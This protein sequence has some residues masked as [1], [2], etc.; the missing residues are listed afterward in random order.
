MPHLVNGT[1]TRYYGKDN[2]HRHDAYCEDCGRHRML[3]SYDARC[4]VALFFL[5]LIPLGKR[6]IVDEC[7]DCHRHR[8]VKLKEWNRIR[9]VDLHSAVEELRADPKNEK[10]AQNALGLAVAYQHAETFE[11]SRLLI[12]QSL[13]ENVE[14]MSALGSACV[15]FADLSAAEQA[16]ARALEINDSRDLKES[17]GLVLLRQGKPEIAM[18]RLAH[19]F[20]DVEPDRV[21]LLYLL[22]EGFQA[23]G[24]HESALDVLD[25]CMTNWNPL[26]NDKEFNNYRNTSIKHRQSD[27]KIASKAPKAAKI[28]GGENASQ[29]TPLSRVVP[30]I[31]PALAL[32]AAGLYLFAA[33]QAGVRRVAHV[34][35]GTPVAYTV[36]ID[37]AELNLPPLTRVPLAIGE[38]THRVEVRDAQLQQPAETVEFSTPFWTRPFQSPAFV[39]NPDRAAVIVRAETVF[40]NDPN[41]VPSPNDAQ[42]NVGQMFYSFAN[43]D[44]IFQDFPEQLEASKHTTRILKTRVYHYRDDPRAVGMVA[45]ARGPGFARAYFKN[46]LKFAPSSFHHLYLLAALLEPEELVAYTKARLEDRPPRVEWHRLYQSTMERA[47]PDHDLEAEYTA[48]LQTNPD[49][50]VLQYLLGRVSAD[51]ARADELFRKSTQG[52]EPCAYGHLALAYRQVGMGEFE[53]ALKE[54]ERAVRL[55]PKGPGYRDLEETILLALARHEELL[56]RTVTNRRKQPYKHLLVIQHIDLLIRMGR[57]NEVAEEIDGYCDLAEMMGTKGPNLTALRNSLEDEFAYRRGDEKA[58]IERWNASE[59]PIERWQGLLHDARLEEAVR[60]LEVAEVESFEPHALLYIAAHVHGQSDLATRHLEIAIEDLR[61]QGRLK[62]RFGEWLSTSI[63]P[64]PEIVCAQPV[65]VRQKR[66]LLTALG[67]RHE[68]HRDRYFTLASRLNFVGEFPQRFLQEVHA[69]PGE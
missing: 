5:P 18:R 45:R 19:I 30:V 33:Y 34:V 69:F 3:D 24:Q 17:L 64:D 66:I 46:T 13:G 28:A 9:E 65:T 11:A 23:K 39:I 48:R 40:S 51:L 10:K 44:Y 32:L 59:D 41:L 14:V 58:I 8:V 15:C 12:E 42:A 63:P 35:N 55:N 49:E 29:R 43:I 52:P 27:K 6:R 56:K 62:R 16:Y 36:V 25:T 7:P 2:R 26:T 37:G 31:A 22:V 67:L 4:Y 60:Q 53:A 20:H 50:P 21:E 54:A 47:H 1:G 57:S 61:N 38:G 68:Q